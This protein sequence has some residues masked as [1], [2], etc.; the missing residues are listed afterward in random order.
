MKK[1]FIFLFSVFLITFMGCSPATGEVPEIPA[2]EAPEEF[3]VFAL[4]DAGNI[5]AD[6]DEINDEFNYT[7]DVSS[8]QVNH[9]FYRTIRINNTVYIVKKLEVKDVIQMKAE[10][11]INYSLEGF[12]DISIRI[13]ENEYYFADPTS[14]LD[15]RD[16]IDPEKN[17]PIC[18]NDYNVAISFSDLYEEVVQ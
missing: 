3:E 18:F 9:F 6:I 4:D 14:P 8:E 1:F 13:Y 5:I 2:L 11:I 12:P 15:F 16:F 10:E 17:A 7:D